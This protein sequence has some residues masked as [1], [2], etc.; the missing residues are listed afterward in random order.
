MAE[1]KNGGTTTRIG[2]RFH[3]EIEFVKDERLAKRKSKDRVS[4]EKLTNLIVRHK[5][6]PTIKED[7][8]IAE[9]KE[10]DQFGL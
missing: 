3:K 5:F 1:K 2:K 7:L 9:Q 6:W 10:V 4:S 8:I